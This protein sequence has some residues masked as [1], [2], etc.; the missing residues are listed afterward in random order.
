MVAVSLAVA[1]I[2]E[3]LATVVTV[4]L[5]IGV[6]KMSQHNAV[7]RRLTAVETLGCTQVIC[8]DKTGTLTQNKMTV[9]EH[10]GP[11]GLLGTAMTLC[12]D[13]VENPDGT[14]QGEPTE[15]ALVRFGVDSG[16]DKNRLE[17]EQPRAAEAP[18]DSSRKMMSTIHRMDN[19]FIQYTKGAP[20]EVLRR[21]TRYEES[22]QMLPMT[23]EKRQEI[24][25]QNKAM[26]DKALR[27]LAAAIRLWEG[28]L[29]KDDSPE[30]LEQDLCFVGLA[31]MID[32]V[33]PEVK[34]AIQQCRTAGIRPVMITGDHKDTAVAIAKEL[35]TGG[36]KKDPDK[37]FAWFSRTEP[38][39]PTALYWLAV[40]HDNGTGVERDPV[41]AFE[42]FQESAKLGYLPAV[43]D[44]GVTGQRPTR[45][46]R[47]S[48]FSR[49]PRRGTSGP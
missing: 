13:A 45:S 34:A 25:A 44:L 38:D 22:G 39:D 30:Y 18:F 42:L 36:V 23:E 24:L 1:A 16:L 37:A 40:C 47:R 28:G 11:E 20:D 48:S 2:P 35:G 43:C 7:I 46:R 26:A 33:R 49:P 8:S 4:V 29:P 12:N 14:V 27:V 21:C 9:V 41:R 5:S 15:A 17:Q 10:T 32:P 3:G 31:G 6:T 19:G